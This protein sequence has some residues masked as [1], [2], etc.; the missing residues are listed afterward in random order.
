MKL[1]KSKNEIDGEGMYNLTQFF[2]LLL[3]VDMR[4]NPHYY[5]SNRQSRENQE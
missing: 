3:K 2:R 1:E 5:E 4:V